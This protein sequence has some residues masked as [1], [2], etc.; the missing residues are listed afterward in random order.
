MAEAVDL[1]KL[2]GAEAVDE[3][4]R[5][6]ARAER[7]GDGDLASILAH[8]RS[9]EVIELPTRSGALC[10]PQP[11]ALD[12]RLGGVRAMIGRIR[13]PVAEEEA[14]RAD[15]SPSKEAPRVIAWA[16]S[17]RGGDR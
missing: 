14:L 12:R 9:A 6:A 5:V 15:L 13:G 2:H 17:A 1:A 7:F 11:A 8:H 16:D 3:A 10:G 4:L